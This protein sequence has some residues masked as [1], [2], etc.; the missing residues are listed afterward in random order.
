MTD[1]SALSLL[2]GTAL[3]GTISLGDAPWP[4]PAPVPDPLE[5]APVTQTI[6]LVD[7]ADHQAGIWTCTPGAFVSNHVGYVE[8]MHV[9]DGE[10]ELRGEDG[11]VWRIEPGT[12]L[13]IPDGW[14]GVWRVTKKVTKSFAIFRER[15]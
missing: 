11:T 8:C 6:Y 9:V 14:K 10:A 13:V 4:A 5:G 3:S 1:P 7:G 2:T 12:L 15:T